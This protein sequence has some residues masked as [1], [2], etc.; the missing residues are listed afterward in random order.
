MREYGRPQLSRAVLTSFATSTSGPRTHLA[1]KVTNPS[2]STVRVKLNPS[3]VVT[4]KRLAALISLLFNRPDS[5]RAQRWEKDRPVVEEE[6]YG[7]W[8]TDWGSDDQA[9]A[10][11]I[12]E[13]KEVVD[14]PFLRC[15]K[16]DGTWGLVRHDAAS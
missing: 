16:D 8:S 13:D 15:N 2:M 11:D 12:H 14:Y 3:S 5:I 10:A 1:S 7:D 4:N 6:D 9:G